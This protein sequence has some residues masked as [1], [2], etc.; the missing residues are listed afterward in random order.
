MSTPKCAAIGFGV[1]F[2]VGTVIGGAFVFLVAL[3]EF[4]SLPSALPDVE[5]WLGS[6][7][8][9]AIAAIGGSIVGAITGA[10]SW[11]V[12]ALALLLFRR[13]QR[14]L[15]VRVCTVGIGSAV[16]AA[17]VLWFFATRPGLIIGVD[18][19]IASSAVAAGLAIVALLVSDRMGQRG[20]SGEESPQAL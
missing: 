16:G 11:S 12:A 1:A 20:L 18:I 5:S 4:R 7:G 2:A 8:V 13:R 6:L 3:V 17:L 15:A 9:A 10:A 14:V 19:I